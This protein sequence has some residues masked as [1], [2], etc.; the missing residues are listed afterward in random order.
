MKVELPL[1]WKGLIMDRYDKTMD[2]GEHV[3]VFTTQLGLYTL[4]DTIFCHVFPT[5]LKASTLSW[6]TRLPS[7]SI[8]CFETLVA[9]F[10]TQFS[11]SKP[12]HLNSLALVNIHQE[13]VE[14]LRVFIECFSKMML[15]IRNLN[16]E[17]AL[18]HLITTL[19]SGPFVDNLQRS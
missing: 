10:G 15:N 5:S 14:S 4:D 11:T 1:K 6:F 18:H 19:R 8:D 13:R 9:C 12:R 16:P 17:V 7:R 3:D 2:P